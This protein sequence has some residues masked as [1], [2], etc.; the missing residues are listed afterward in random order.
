MASISKYKDGW[1]AQ[2][3]VGGVRESAVFGEEFEARAWAKRREAELS[4]IKDTFVRARRVNKN[5]RVVLDASAAY[6]ESEIV[7]NSLSLNVTCGVYFLIKDERIVYVGKSSDVYKRIG[8]HVKTKEFDRITVVECSETDV[9]RLEAMYIDK[10]KPI[11][12]IYG[13]SGNSSYSKIDD[14]IEVAG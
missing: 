11:L 13:K 2:L 8:Q 10:F 4:F 12:N 5:H 3:Y 6:S 7:A 14:F 9:S 1:R